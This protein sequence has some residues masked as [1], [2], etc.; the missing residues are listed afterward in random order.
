MIRRSMPGGVRALLIALFF[1]AGT[2]S[3]VHAAD[4]QS[5]QQ[6]MIEGKVLGP[7]D[8]AASGAI[9]YLQ[10]AKTNEIK[11]YIATA[12]GGYRFGQ[13][14]IDTDYTLWAE[15]RGKKSA[16]KTITAFANKKQLQINLRITDKIK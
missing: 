15:L 16:T 14:A 2:G 1:L 11:S 9:V 3:I 13:M 4:P 12:D 5:T 7:G 10:S 6:K 8:V